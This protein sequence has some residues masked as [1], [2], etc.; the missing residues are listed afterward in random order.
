M[1][2]AMFGRIGES[3]GPITPPGSQRGEKYI[4]EFS[5]AFGVEVLEP[6]A[7]GQA[8]IEDLK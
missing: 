4:P 2:L 7:R 8:R 5:A 1:S 6:L 3:A